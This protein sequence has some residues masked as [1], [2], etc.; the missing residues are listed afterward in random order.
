MAKKSKSIAFT[1]ATIDLRDM[2]IA[3]LKKD[4][5]VVSSLQDLLEEWDGVEGISL[6]IKQDIQC[7]GME[8]SAD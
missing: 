6:V 8:G 2:T 7:G 4:S 5:V 3:E 1:N